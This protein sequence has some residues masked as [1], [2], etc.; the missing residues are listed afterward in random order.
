[1]ILMTIFGRAPFVRMV[2]S[3]TRHHNSSTDEFLPTLSSP[4]REVSTE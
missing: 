4:I 1:M 3:S 2:F